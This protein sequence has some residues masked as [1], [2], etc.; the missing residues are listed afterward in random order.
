MCPTLRPPLFVG[1]P[2]SQEV[3][4][5][6]SWALSQHLFWLH[7]P[8]EALK[9]VLLQAASN[10]QNKLM[11]RERQLIEHEMKPAVWCSS[12]PAPGS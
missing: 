3:I 8:T 11:E 10:H 7:L 4:H 6:V 1:I 2:V 9:M 5:H 12:K